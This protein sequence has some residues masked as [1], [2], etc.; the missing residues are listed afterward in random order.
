MARGRPAEPV[1]PSPAEIITEIDLNRLAELIAGAAVAGALCLSSQACAAKNDPLPGEGAAAAAAA[2]AP[3]EAPAAAKDPAAAAPAPAASAAGDPAPAKAPAAGVEA[4]AALRGIPAAH[5]RLLE[6]LARET[7][8]VTAAE[9]AAAYRKAAKKQSIIDAMN[10]PG[11]AKPWYKYR[12]IFIIPKRIA[13]G[14]AFLKKNRAIF[15]EAAAKYGVNPEIVAAIIGVETFYGSSMGTYRVLDALYTLGFHYPKRADYFSREFANY[16]KLAKEQKWGLGDRK[17]SY[18]GAMGMGQFMP[19]SYLR[20][21]VDH[22]G[23]GTA[24]LF[25]SRADAIASVANY[26]N[27]HEWKYGE[28]VAVRVEAGDPGKVGRFLGGGSSKPDTTVGELKKLGVTVPAGY[29]DAEPCK[30]LR[31]RAEKGWEYYLGFHN[32]YVITR[33]NKSPLYAMAVYDLSREL[34]RE[35]PAAAAQPEAAARPAGTPVKAEKQGK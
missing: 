28:P 4:A 29:A 2:P 5:A 1:P 11:E 35:E 13:E 25:G 6:K 31:L 10:R 7:P 19:W 9:L 3:A 26:F 18:A 22:D 8:G 20:W 14:R 34:L 23:D 33:Y 12:R 27:A 24:D 30:L 16:V 15:A 21:A 32:F 17:G